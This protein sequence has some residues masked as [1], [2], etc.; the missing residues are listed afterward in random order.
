MAGHKTRLSRIMRNGRV[1]LLAM[2][3]GLEHGPVDF[4]EKNINP[5]YVLDIAA[6]GGFTGLA[7][8]KGIAYKYLENYAGQ[9]PLVLKLNGK[10]NIVPKDEAYSAPVATVKEAIKLG[11]DAIGYTIYVGSP[12]EA[13]MFHEFGLI[14][15]ECEEYGI[16]T[17]V[18]AYPRGKYIP[19]EKDKNVVAYAA[20]C[21]LELGADIVKVN[22]T[23]SIESFKY[24]VQAAQ[25]CKVISAGGSKQTDEEFLAKAKEVMQAGAVGFAVG[26]NVWQHPHPLE[27]T[28]KLK[29]IIFSQ[30]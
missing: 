17:I 24:V 22:Y 4:N 11:A 28:E 13:K 18:W 10:T 12:N 8:Q 1:M 3:Q 27:I 2:D 29:K 20:R 25:K 30:Y 26:R 19:D 6:K 14:R 5:D 15:A 9:V 21:A 7:I 16:P 23:G